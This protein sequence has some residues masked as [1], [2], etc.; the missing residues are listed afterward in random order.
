[1]PKY[2]NK[3]VRF[4]TTGVRGT[5]PQG[6]RVRFNARGRLATEDELIRYYGKR[7]ARRD[8]RAARSRAEAPAPRQKY[9]LGS[10]T[11]KI[12]HRRFS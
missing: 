11:R 4:T 8:A 12:S 2:L 1:M 10:G 3:R 6:I 5:M 7:Q 9:V